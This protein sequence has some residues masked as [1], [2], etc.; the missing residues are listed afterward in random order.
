MCFHIFRGVIEDAK[1][2][3]MNSRCAVTTENDSRE[4]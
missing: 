1:E 4:R 2:R 3:A